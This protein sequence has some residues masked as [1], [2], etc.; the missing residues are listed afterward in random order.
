MAAMR[1][2]LIATVLLASCATQPPAPKNEWARTYLSDLT[3]ARDTIAADHPGMLDDQNPAFRA[4]MRSAYAEAERAMSAVNDYDSYRTALTRFIN[5]FQDAHLGI[6]FKKPYESLQEAGIVM[7]RRGDKFIVDEADTRYP[8]D[9]KGATLES[10]DGEAARKHFERRVLSWRGR[11][12]VEADWQTLAPILFVDYGPPTPRVPKS[13]RF[14]AGGLTI[15]VALQ[16]TPAS[17]ERVSAILNRSANANRELSL[18]RDGDVV[19]V[20]IPTFAVND[21]KSI[22]DMRALIDSLK[23]EVEGRKDWRL[24]VFDLRGNQG[25]SSV[26][27][28]QI[29]S[30]VFGEEWTNRA[31]RWLRD[32]VYTEWRVSPDNVNAVAG[33]ARQA[34]E[35]HGVDSDEAKSMRRFHEQMSAALA[36]GEPLFSKPSQRSD[37]KPPEPVALPGKVVVVSSSSCFSACLDFL[38]F[39]LVHPAVVQVGQTTGVDTVYMENWGKP[40]P[41]GLAQ[42]GYPMKV[43]RNRRRGNNEPY[44]PSARFDALDDTDALRRWIVESYR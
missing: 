28:Q 8:R 11:P 14:I 20:S 39:M 27:G 43:Y 1:T 34:E 30:T 36:R 3:A 21:E 33:N 42:I 40:L 24:L 22:A 13:C 10:C 31:I 44:V 2:V 18:S 26:W 6:S 38:D 9:L 41:S 29:A 12:S 32:G 17:Q 35:R 15:D 19:W 37:V 4:T 25:G 7:V 23:R 5:R 16:W